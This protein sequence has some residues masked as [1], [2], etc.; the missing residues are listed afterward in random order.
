M[1]HS[2][3]GTK[4]SIYRVLQKIVISGVWCKIVPFLNGIFQYF[5]DLFFKSTK[6]MINTFFSQNQKFRKAKIQK[7]CTQKGT[8]L[9][10]TPLFTRFFYSPCI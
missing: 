7:S 1:N 10:Q 2:E 4:T 9:H 5:S 3:P 6:K 8:I